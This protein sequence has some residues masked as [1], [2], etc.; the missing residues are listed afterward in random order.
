MSAQLVSTRAD[1][2]R[3]VRVD[4]K[5]D[6]AVVEDTGLAPTGSG[7]PML[8]VGAALRKSLGNE[9]GDEVRVVLLH[10]LT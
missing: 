10:R 3:S 8:S 9:V 4:V 6:G 1:S 2:L 5:V 7:E